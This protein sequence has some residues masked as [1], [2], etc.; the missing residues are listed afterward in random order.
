VGLSEKAAQDC[1]KI[2]SMLSAS[3]VQIIPVAIDGMVDIALLNP[4]S[5]KSIKTYLW[6]S[7][8]LCR[9][10]QQYFSMR[11]MKLPLLMKHRLSACPQI[12]T[13]QTHQ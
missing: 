8:I 13:L 10:V 6:G 1:R 7:K 11:P 12:P 5:S 2:V 3:K 4:S 9:G